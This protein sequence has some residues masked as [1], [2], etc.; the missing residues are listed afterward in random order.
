MHNLRGT[1]TQLWSTHIYR[2]YAD[3]EDA[4]D[5]RKYFPQSKV[6]KERAAA[7]SAASQSED[8]IQEGVAAL[9]VAD[10]ATGTDTGASGTGKK[11]PPN[12]LEGEHDP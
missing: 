10:N 7:A 2:Y 3:S 11:Q 8:A 5:M 1:E 12:T 9:A 4:Y 6:C